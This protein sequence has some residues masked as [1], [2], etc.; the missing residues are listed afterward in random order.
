[1]LCTL[2]V[3]AE[4]VRRRE[5]IQEAAMFTG[6]QSTNSLGIEGNAWIWGWRDMEKRMGHMSDVDQWPVV[7]EPHS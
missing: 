6:I 2:Y 7:V 4:G 5:E 1:M 3:V